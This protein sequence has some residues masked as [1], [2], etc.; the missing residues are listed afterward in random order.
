VPLPRGRW[1]FIYDPPLQISTNGKRAEAILRI[2]QQCTDVIE[3]YIRRQPE[4]W[5]WMHRRWK[6][7]PGTE[8]SDVE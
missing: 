6:A 5:L 3:N 7:Q 8:H 2:T 1:R 4:I